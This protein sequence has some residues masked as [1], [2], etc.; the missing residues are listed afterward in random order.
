MKDVHFNLYAQTKTSGDSCNAGQLTQLV[1]SRIR[2]F[3]QINLWYL[4]GT[5]TPRMEVV[6]LPLGLQQD[7][8]FQPIDTYINQI[9]QLRRQCPPPDTGKTNID[10]FLLIGIEWT[11]GVM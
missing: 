5:T 6:V 10:N 1:G 7:I 3:Y 8:E 9:L 11:P 2:K 4:L